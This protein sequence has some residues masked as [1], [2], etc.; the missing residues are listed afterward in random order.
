MKIFVKLFENVWK[1]LIFAKKK[2]F[3]LLNYFEVMR[4]DKQ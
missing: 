3:S 4:N 1:K 2:I